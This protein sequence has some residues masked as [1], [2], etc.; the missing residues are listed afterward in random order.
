MTWIRTTPLAGAE[1]ALRKAL[2]AQRAMYPKEYSSP[3][4]PGGDSIV[5]AHALMPDA[6]YH[7]FAGFG[8]MMTPDLPLTRAQHEMIATMV[9]ITNKCFY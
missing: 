6:L 7:V 4:Q 9:S 3:V 5:Q 8:A 2:A 1:E